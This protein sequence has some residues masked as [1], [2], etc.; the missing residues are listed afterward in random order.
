MMVN[1]L[2]C[3]FFKDIIELIIMDEKG[4]FQENEGNLE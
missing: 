2:A 1:D 4:L 3:Y